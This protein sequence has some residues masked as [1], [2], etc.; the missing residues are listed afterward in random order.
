V[1]SELNPDESR[2]QA[3]EDFVARAAFVTRREQL[4][5]ATAEVFDAFRRAG[6]DAVLLKGAALAG[7]LY[8]PEEPRGYFDIDV[9]ISP[10]QRVAAGEVLAE[11]GYRNFSESR[12]VDDVGRALHAD[13]WL[14][15]MVGFR[16]GFAGV[17]ID[18][19]RRLGGCEAPDALV[20]QALS[21]DRGWVEVAGTAVPTLGRPGLALGV[22]LHVA[23]HGPADIKAVGDL[24]R[25]L[26][27][28]PLEVWREAASLAEDVGGDESFAGG[29]RLLP[30]GAELAD[31]LGLGSAERVLWDLA[32]R[33]SRP[34]G[35]FHLEALAQARSAREKVNIIRRALL[36]SRDWMG[37]EM[38]WATRSRA[39]LA[40]AYFA[41][42]LRAPAWA[43]RA[44][45]YSRRRLVTSGKQRVP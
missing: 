33:G 21:A 20:W 5:A 26:E 1:G 11:L 34:R 40:A 37:W 35:T 4:D 23:Q 19:H 3:H 36:P 9:L 14:G 13:I 2:R 30:A 44:R 15:A 22:A 8:P 38:R 39:H 16:Y 43:V 28:W 24:R 41:H 32:N 12:G 27:R 10:V 18:L 45:R 17:I 7:A 25:A 6:I 42:I 29:L 31:Q